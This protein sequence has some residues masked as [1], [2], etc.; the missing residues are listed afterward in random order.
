MVP[1]WCPPMVSQWRY[2][3]VVILIFLSLDVIK[4]FCYGVSSPVARAYATACC[5]NIVKCLGSVLISE[6][7]TGD[8]SIMEVEDTQQNNNN[9]NG[10]RLTNLVL[11]AVDIIVTEEFEGISSKSIKVILYC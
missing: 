1:Q 8:D 9:N 5:C 7:V 4:P 6:E 3:I 10:L 2:S 11:L